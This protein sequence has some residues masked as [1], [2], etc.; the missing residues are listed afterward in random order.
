M[1]WPGNARSNN[2]K[3][4][5]FAFFQIVNL[6]CLTFIVSMLTAGAYGA[7]NNVPPIDEK[8]VVFRRL[9]PEVRLTQS[10]VTAIA[11]DGRLGG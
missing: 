10:Q 5:S 8:Q 6:I 11:Q 4:R 3:I 7:T 9:P 1:S 2:I